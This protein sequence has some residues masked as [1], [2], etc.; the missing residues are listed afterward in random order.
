MTIVKIVS[1]T[2]GYIP[3]GKRFVVPTT[4]QDPPIGVD[5]AEA[6]RLAELGVAVIVDRPDAERAEAPAEGPAE[7]ENG[8][9]DAEVNPE[10]ENGAEGA[11]EAEEKDLEDMSFAELKKLG[12]E[13]GI[14]P[15]GL[16]SR[17]D[18]IS[19]IN[20]AL[21]EEPRVTAEEVIEG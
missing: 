5:D 20:A 3:K 8:A 21:E 9:G 17:R 16:K 1:G 2:Y 6:K 14:N 19:A 12:A 11:P 10:P 7:G 13:I 15:T 4:P 18:Y